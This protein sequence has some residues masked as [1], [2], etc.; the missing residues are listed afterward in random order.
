[1]GNR[2]V[3]GA[4]R[5]RGAAH[6][7]P[8]P[9]VGSGTTPFDQADGIDQIAR[10]AVDLPRGAIGRAVPAQER[11][12]MQRTDPVPSPGQQQ[13]TLDAKL[14]CVEVRPPV[15]AQEIRRVVDPIRIIEFEIDGIVNAHRHFPGVVRH[16]IRVVR[17]PILTTG[18]TVN[19]HVDIEFP[20]FTA[21]I[22][23]EKIAAE[24]K[25]GPVVMAVE[26]DQVARRVGLVVEFVLII[27]RIQRP[28]VVL[29]PVLE[30]LIPDGAA[31]HVR[32][33]VRADHRPLAN[34]DGQCVHRPQPRHR[35]NA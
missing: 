19:R 22:Q 3:F 34:G 11:L 32:I 23:I 4:A 33:L 12:E 31:G 28:D 6:P 24:I 30:L 35:A 21:K 1:M 25:I 10:L 8:Q 20:L 7:A 18:R 15:A 26:R 9:A 2:R 17:Q 14:H 5:G 29:R 27:I 16:G 13:R